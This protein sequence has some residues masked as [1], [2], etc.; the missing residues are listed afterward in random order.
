VLDNGRL[1]VALSPDLDPVR[2][3]AFAHLVGLPVV[4]RDDAPREGGH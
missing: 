4:D 2:L 1:S 3:E